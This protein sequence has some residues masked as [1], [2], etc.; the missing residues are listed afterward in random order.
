MSSTIRFTRNAVSVVPVAIY[1]RVSTQGQVGGRFDSCESQTAIC[2][3]YLQRMSDQ[4]WC[5]VGAFTDAAYSGSSMNRPGI[6]AVKRLIEAGEIKVVL[7]YKF[8]RM[9][10]NTDDWGPFRTFLQKHGCRLVSTTED[11]SEDTPSGR[12]KNNFMVSVAEYERLNTI[13]KVRAKMLQQAKRG[14]W[15][16]GPV[17]FGY[18]YDSARQ[19][20]Y[21][22]PT[23]AEVVRRIF[24]D[25]AGLVSLTDLANTL[26]EEG[27]RTRVRTNKLRDGE[28]KE[29][30]GKRFRSDNLRHI[31]MNPI[32]AGKVRFLREE[33][34][35]RHQALVD[36]AL[37]ERAN[38]AVAP[39][40][41]GKRVR[42]LRKSD[43]H[44]NLLKGLFYC[45]HCGLA[46]I[47]VVSGKMT[48]KGPHRYYTCGKARSERD[49]AECPVRHVSAKAMEAVVV[50][51]VGRLAHHPDIA[52]RIAAGV[53]QMPRGDLEGIRR[54]LDSIRAE[55]EGVESQ[56]RRCAELLVAGTQGLDE[57]IKDQAGRLKI[58]KTELLVTAERQRQVVEMHDHEVI[59]VART[60]HAML[61]F[62]RFLPSLTAEEQKRLL[63]LCFE[64][65][66]VRSGGNSRA[67]DRRLELLCE[68]L[69]GPLIGAMDER[70]VVQKRRPTGV[71]RNSLLVS[72]TVHLS[73][74][75]R[76][77]M[78]APFEAVFESGRI[79]KPKGPKPKCAA[80]INRALAWKRTL[81]AEA[82]HLTRL[83]LAKREGVCPATITYHLNLLRLA[84][85]ILAILRR[86]DAMMA[87]K[88]VRLER[89]RELAKQPIEE[90]RRLWGIWNLQA[91]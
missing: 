53:R 32:Y 4:G 43:K 72:V 13:E 85:E 3:E 12:L 41:A 73:R 20:L 18:A 90:Q 33:Y 40:I 77:A 38:A 56:L 89:M 37:W 65:I 22:H 6:Q 21:P 88:G 5:E 26:A 61:E 11:L 16:F 35:G 44:F 60:Q 81:N 75:S 23:E 29:I 50:G 39:R 27:V 47:P 69:P 36:A 80:A 63:G 87:G 78:T 66:T 67:G 19:A 24:R 51:F 57:E 46:M 83:A 48:A 91:A 82:P 58:R 68:L 34:A 64:R 31:V 28:I 17:P 71:L 2:R 30:G 15:N 1:A 9:L 79:T 14:F 84:P 10:R 42:R 52:G 59:D 25:A 8:E 74:G 62:G 7:I 45:G 55:I 70:L 54:Q 49:E 86:P 76:V